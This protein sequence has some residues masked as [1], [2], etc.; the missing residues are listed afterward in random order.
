MSKNNKVGYHY[1]DALRLLFILAKGSKAISN[2]SQQFGTH[3]FEGEKRLMAIDF[4]MRYPDYLADKLLDL[5]EES[6]D[7]DLYSSIETIFD[8]EE[9]DVRTV[10]M[11]RWWRGA[12]QNIETALSILEAY[13]LVKSK[14][15]QISENQK[16]YDFFLGQ[17][18]FDFLDQAVIDQPILK[19]YEERSS[20]V[21]LIAKDYSG[22]RLKEWQYDYEEYKDSSYGA[23]IPSI[24]D[25]VLERL[26]K[27]RREDND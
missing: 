3:I 12:Y 17:S 27:I 18:A 22:T 16:R 25:R 20:L 23:M 26:E 1:R 10:S 4:W 2:E 19:W 21:M 6:K 11:L 14:I 7:A 8:N 24:K 9:P 15:K 13:N 5:Y